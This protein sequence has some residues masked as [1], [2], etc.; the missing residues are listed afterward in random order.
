MWSEAWPNVSMRRAS[1]TCGRGGM[2][3]RG[4]R[5][6]RAVGTEATRSR[7]RFA[8]DLRNV[9]SALKLGLL[10]EGGADVY[11]RL[12]P[13]CEWDTAAAQ[14]VLEAA[15]G[16]VLQLTGVP[17]TYNKRDILNPEFVAVAD[18]AVDW[19]RFFR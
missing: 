6:W 8:P 7:P 2:P 18:P 16:A 10:A 4:R 1:A 12:A 11:P 9:G 13:T 17:V 3:G 5:W 14:A 19:L 15:G